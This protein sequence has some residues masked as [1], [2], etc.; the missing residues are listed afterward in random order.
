LPRPLAW[1]FTESETVLP[2]AVALIPLAGVFQV[3]DG[4]QVVCI[5]VLRGLAE[6][7]TP[8]IANAVGFWGIGLPLGWWLA[9]EGGLGPAGLWWGLVAGLGT[10]AAF[11]LARVVWRI[12]RGGTSS[13]TA[14][15]AAAAPAN[16]GS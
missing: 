7:R 12:R 10:V 9:F 14:I 15:D 6:T 5:G 3:F 8:L 16:A 1:L 11:L 4:I 13:A 2:I